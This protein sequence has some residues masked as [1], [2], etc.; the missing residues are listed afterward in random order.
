M[1]VEAELPDMKA[2][3]MANEGFY[4]VKIIHQHR[5]RQGWQFSAL[6]EGFEVY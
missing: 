3:E 4:M 2:E 5:Y 1:V 6:W